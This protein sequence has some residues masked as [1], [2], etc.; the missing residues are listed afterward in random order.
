MSI[1]LSATI[2]RL[3]RRLANYAVNHCTYV[4]E[5]T[6][7]IKLYNIRVTTGCAYCDYRGLHLL[8]LHMHYNNK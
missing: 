5:S 4:Y 7:C 8:E 3:Y 6:V 1:I 2:V